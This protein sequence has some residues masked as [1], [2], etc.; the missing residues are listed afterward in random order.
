MNGGSEA[1]AVVFLSAANGCFARVSERRLR[2]LCGLRGA[3]LAI[4]F[5][6]V[7]HAAAESAIED[8]LVT[9]T[10]APQEAL[11]A[12]VSVL[13]SQ[14]IQALNKTSVADL[15]KTL[16][17]L[18]VEEQGGPGG[19]AAVSIRGG[20]SN[21]TLVMV[22]GV[23]VNDPTNVRGG[24]FDLSNINPNTVDRIEVVRGAQ[25]AIYG[26]DALAGVINIITRRAPQGHSQQAR[27]EVGQD[28]YADFGLS[29][30]GSE[31]DL[32]YVLELAHRD[33][34]EPVPGSARNSDNANLRLGWQFADSQELRVSYRYLDGNRT[35]YPE[36]SGGEAYALFD[37][38]DT[39]QFT[40]SIYSLDW[41][42]QLLSWWRSAV[43][44]N[45]FGQDEHYRSPGIAPYTEVPP[46]GSDTDFTR[47]QLRWINTLQIARNY[48]ASIG[49]DVRRE[50]GRSTGYVEFFGERSPTDFELKRDT[51]AVF[52][53][54][55]VTPLEAVLVHSSLRYDDPQDFDSKT[56]AQAGLKYSAGGG[57][58]LAANW[59]EAYKLPSFFAL[60]H[61][62]V[63]NPDLEPEQGESW[64]LGV[65]W[66]ASAALRLGATGFY[67]DFRDLVDFDEETFRNINRQNVQTQG[68]EFQAD[69]RAMP[70]LEFRSQATYTDIDVKNEDAVLNA[71]PQWT[72]SM[73]AQWRIAAQWDS[74]LDYT[75]HG[76]QWSSSRHTGAQVTEELDDYHIVDWVLRWQ[77]APSW[78]WQLS[79]DN[80]LDERYETAVGFYAP[81]REVRLGVVFNH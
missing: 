79:V 33:D 31:G 8:V 72:A 5:G 53:G 26:S 77:V 63:G 70:T 19:L 10:L 25:S 21:F 43:T 35:S 49:A 40:Q 80:L 81:Q 64:D 60:G 73:V 20:E 39:S 61:A 12:S 34:G 7:A 57:M 22:D 37:A 47:D 16:P 55:S 2:L 4:V 14:Q 67:N 17:G 71:R 36:Q 69:W 78:Q 11:T 27:A 1:Q 44:A 38:L 13:D 23:A 52:A 9:G 3:L 54:L 24:S 50:D 66:D 75:Y 56:S 42:A 74:A 46:N 6:A 68:V 32:D 58:T 48:E 30:L 15:L 65:S 41:S 29:A 18:L 76:Q 45:R 62:L 28:D 59:G 51:R